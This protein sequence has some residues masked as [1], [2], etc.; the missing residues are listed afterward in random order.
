MTITDNYQFAATA[1]CF[2]LMNIKAT[3]TRRIANKASGGC[4]LHLACFYTCINLL[5][6]YLLTDPP[7]LILIP[8]LRHTTVFL[9]MPFSL[10]YELP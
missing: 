2:K 8:T 6:L 1:L 7:T 5:S 3:E 9:S 4:A 10:I